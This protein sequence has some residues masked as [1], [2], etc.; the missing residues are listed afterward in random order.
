M[1]YQQITISLPDR[2]YQQVE[3][4]SQA[5]QRSMAEEVVAAVS[6]ALP[7]EAQLPADLEAEL[8]HLDQLNDE[9]LWRAAR[10]TAPK[11]KTERMQVLVDK[12]QLEGLTSAEREEAALMSHFFNRIMLVRAKA[13]VLLKARGHH[14]DAL[15]DE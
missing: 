5:R 13:A 4:L 6:A 15:L 14:I 9:E 7:E 2:L 10:M 8:A 1:S 12:Q 11:E 3:K